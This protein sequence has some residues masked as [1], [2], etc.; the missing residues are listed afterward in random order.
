MLQDQDLL[1]AALDISTIAAIATSTA[2]SVNNRLGQSLLTMNGILSRLGYEAPVAYTTGLTISRPTQTVQNSGVIYAIL[3]SVISAV[4]YATPG[5]FDSSKWYV[6]QIANSGNYDTR[7]AAIAANISSTV[8]Y[9]R[10]AGNVTY[11][12]G[13][14]A[15]YVRV[16]ALPTDGFGFTSADGAFWSYMPIAGLYVNVLAAD[17]AFSATIAT[18]T[19]AYQAALNFAS[20]NSRKLYFAPMTHTINSISIAYNAIPEFVGAYSGASIIKHND[21]DANPLINITGGLGAVSGVY[22]FSDLGGLIGLTLKG[23]TTTTALIYFAGHFGNNF[24]FHDLILDGS[25]ASSSMNG[26]DCFDYAGCNMCSMRWVEIGGWAINVR[27]ASHFPHAAFKCD[28]F[29]WSNGTHTAWG[30]GI[31]QINT[32]NLS[33]IK[34]PV[35]FINGAA[36]A[37]SP[38]SSA[39]P[40]RSLF[41]A[42]QNHTW[43]NT[44]F[45][46]VAFLLDCVELDNSSTA[47]DTRVMT[48]DYNHVGYTLTNCDFS[49]FFEFFNNDALTAKDRLTGAF[50]VVNHIDFYT[51]LNVSADVPLLQRINGN[52]G[53]QQLSYDSDLDLSL[54]YFASGDYA[55]SRQPFAIAG[56]SGRY[57]AKKSVSQNSGVMKGSSGTP[58]QAGTTGAIVSGLA[59]LTLSLAISALPVVAGM[60]IEVAGAGV[61]GATLRS[62]IQDIDVSTPTAPKLT[63]ADNAGTTVTTATVQIGFA[64]LMSVPMVWNVT[65][66][67]SDTHNKYQVGD[68][69]QNTA[70]QGTAGGVGSPILEWVCIT[71]NTQY[72]DVGAWRA[73]KWITQMGTTAQ[74]P[75]MSASNIGVTYLDQTLAAN[76]KPIMWNGTVW[77]DSTG[78]SV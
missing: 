56:M 72:T 76:G 37:T 7:A 9:I 32:S 68:I 44:G 28:G 19:A 16:V 45:A 69:A 71:T 39:K 48:C 42:I 12:D 49:G 35:K 24:K 1:N 38:L 36:K 18:R 52:L 61:A 22:P 33:D 11:G 60:R 15:E 13:G 47:Y 3:P 21:G 10:L 6:V 53:M 30:A 46:Q 78:A 74:R 66:F 41:R 77:V 55:F 23:G 29:Y 43:L 20:V 62:I 4:S 70:P 65:A 63:L 8:N 50:G 51:S 17:N 67:P 58:L 14:Y 75:T 2:L 73:A 31:M 54:G 59:V 34:G 26:I 5:V 57:F 64:E 27:D 25:V 40:A